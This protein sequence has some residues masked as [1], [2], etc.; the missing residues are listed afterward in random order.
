MSVTQTFAQKVDTESCIIKLLDV[1][2]KAMSFGGSLCLN[3]YPAI[4]A[5]P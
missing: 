5:G 1:G 4:S 3:S 2:S